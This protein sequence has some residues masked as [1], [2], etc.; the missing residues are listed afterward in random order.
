MEQFE[1]LGKK[2]HMI[3]LDGI[4]SGSAKVIVKLPHKEYAAIPEV[5][6]DIN[7]LANLFIDPVNVNVLV[8]D[9]IT[10]RV[11]QL[12]Q[13]KLHE[14]T[15]GEQYYL[16][17]ANQKYAKIS[18]GLATGLSLGSTEILLK[19]RNVIL[20]TAESTMPK[21]RLS[22]VEVEKI[23]LNLLPYYNWVTVENEKHEIAI[24][25]YTK[26]EE[27]IS[28]GSK[29]NMDSSFDESLFKEFTR[30]D[31]GSRIAGQTIKPGSCQVTGTFSN[32][33]FVISI[34]IFD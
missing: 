32:V 3:L 14:I 9:S 23:T 18:G 4:N 5:E 13:G 12:K 17:I 16:E 22:V 6:V 15:L 1:T 24:N 25:L 2:G 7:V 19:D 30:S 8:G 34:T 11:L 33:S 28:L 20:N 29:Y 10:F 31:N 26:S 21:A 27:L